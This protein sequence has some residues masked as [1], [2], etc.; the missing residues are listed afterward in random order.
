MYPTEGMGRRGRRCVQFP[1]DFKENRRYWNL[2]EEALDRTLRGTC[3]RIDY[4][5][6]EG[7]STNQW[8]DE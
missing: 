7:Y 2:K 3:S 1:V 4:E 5:P 8:I 6:V